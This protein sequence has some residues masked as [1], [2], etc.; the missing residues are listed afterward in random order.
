MMNY[1]FVFPDG[2]LTLVTDNLE[3]NFGTDFFLVD[4]QYS[5]GTWSGPE[6]RGWFGFDS[7]NE[8]AEKLYV[9]ED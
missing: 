9:W 5:D 7:L 2:G 8:N 1:L 4:H 3:E 6:R